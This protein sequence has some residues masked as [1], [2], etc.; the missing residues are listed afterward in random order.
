M[1]PAGSV[2]T[3]RDG[4]GIAAGVPVT[5]LEKLSADRYRIAYGNVT[6]L[7]VPAAVLASNRVAKPSK[8]RKPGSGLPG[9]QT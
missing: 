2:V 7:V 4:A 9:L 1:I 8:G 5:I 6:D 3:V